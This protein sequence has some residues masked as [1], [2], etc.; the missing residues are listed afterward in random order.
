[1][2]AKFVAGRLDQDAVIPASVPAPSGQ[3]LGDIQTNR[4]QAGILTRRYLDLIASDKKTLALLLL[5]APII[6]LIAGAVFDPNGPPRYRF[7]V[8]RQVMFTLI[9]SAIWFGSLNS[10]REVVKELPIYLREHAANLK[11]SSYLISKVI[12]LAALGAFQCAILLGVVSHMVPIPGSTLER[13]VV[14]FLTA[15]AA[16][17][18]GLLVS[19]LAPSVDKAVAVIPILL[20]PQMILA[21]VSIRL[22]HVSKV[23]AE[24][25]IISFWSFSAIKETLPQDV[26]AL[27]DVAGSFW[28][29]SIM[30]AVFF[31]GYLTC[32]AIG[33]KLKDRHAFRP[34]RNPVVQGVKVMVLI[35]LPV[36]AALL[37]YF[38]PE[39]RSSIEAW[40]YVRDIV[41][42]LG[43]LQ[44]ESRG[45]G[46]PAPTSATRTAAEE[47]PVG[48]QPPGRQQSEAVNHA[49]ITAISSIL[50]QQNQTIV[51]SGRGFGT[52]TPYNGNSNYLLIRDV[53]RGW[54]AGWDGDWVHLDVAE[55]SDAKIVIK[56]FTGGY[57]AFFWSLQ[58][59]DQVEVDIWNPEL[60]TRP[61]T[62]TTFVG[63]VA[64]PAGP[65]SELAITSISSILPQQNQTIV[66]YGKGFGSRAPYNGNSN[67]L[68]I[69]DVTR[70][71][72]AGWDGNLV[73]LDVVGWSDVKIVIQGFTGA[74]GGSWSLRPGDQVEVHIWNPEA[75]TRPATYTTVVR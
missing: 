4:H 21:D 47:A 19:A 7:S 58:P 15:L 26:R 49:V 74:Y 39:R 41:G 23:I 32:A 33:L 9:M 63:P 62:Y 70:G 29:G 31:L 17:G 57:G 12:P 73:H 34:P 10:A 60:G 46:T 3:S 28:W 61:A 42:R 40:H 27:D 13:W 64:R 48:T 54:N 56:G 36:I 50:A 55:W 2:Y 30:L 52:R 11:L 51:I 59:G 38:G 43:S 16:T 25:S 45:P 1:L 20:I 6:G 35:L 53:T 71:W 66:I 67:Y 72:E 24:A 18:M 37:L 75:G 44:S 22:H 8:D 65:H 68:L 69:R 14:L 5:Q